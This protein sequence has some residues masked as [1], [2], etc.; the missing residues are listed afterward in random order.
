M[1]TTVQPASG[2]T[3]KQLINYR[4]DTGVAEPPA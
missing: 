3:T 2:E 4:I 1:A